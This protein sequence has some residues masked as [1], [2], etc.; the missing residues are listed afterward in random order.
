MFF[1]HLKDVVHVLLSSYIY[2]YK[3][4]PLSKQRQEEEEEEEEMKKASSSLPAGP[5]WG[6]LLLHL[7]P[8][9]ASLIQPGKLE[10]LLCEFR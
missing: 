8:T 1:C 4:A 3:I 7:D 5:V 10:I 2:I 9:A 6:L